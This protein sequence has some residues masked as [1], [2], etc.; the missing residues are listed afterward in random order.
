M[1][2][3]TVATPTTITDV[4][5]TYA[6]YF[7]VGIISLVGIIFWI[8]QRNISKKKSAIVKTE[9]AD[10][11]GEDLP[12]EEPAF[13]IPE[14]PLE[15]AHLQ[16]VN[17]NSSAFY[18]TLDASL[19]KYLSAKFKVP[20]EELNKKRINEE[21]DKCNVG[22]GTSL[23]LTSL[24]DTLELNLYAPASNVQHLKEVY[25]KASEVVSLLDKQVC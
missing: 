17:E 4:L 8:F 9:P 14:S 6:L 1:F 2:Y 13:V 3:N 19:K 22:L 15:N 11:P 18:S 10:L 21:M 25:E 5:K 7:I 24:M 20:A 16:L 23:R 12:K